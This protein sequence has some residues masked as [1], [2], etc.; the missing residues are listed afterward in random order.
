[1]TQLDLKATITTIAK[2]E[3]DSGISLMKA[4]S[5]ENMGIATIVD[6]VKACSGATDDQIDSY[7][8]ENGMEAL[9]EKLIKAFEKS[10]FLAK[11]KKEEVLKTGL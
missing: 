11:T 3:R 7:V 10:G 5:D 1:M 4:F 2:F 6:L 8:E 9:N